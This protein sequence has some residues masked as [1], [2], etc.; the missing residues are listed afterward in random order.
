[1]TP[2]FAARIVDLP[3]LFE[4]DPVLYLGLVIVDDKRSPRADVCKVGKT[5]GDVLVKMS[6]ELYD[7]TGWRA[8]YINGL[9]A[10]VRALR[11]RESE[12]G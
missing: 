10:A 9:R 7:S 2:T 8:E 4:G 6:A 11:E 5:R 12:N 3:P 1:M